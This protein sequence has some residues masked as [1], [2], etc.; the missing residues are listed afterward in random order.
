[1]VLLGAPHRLT[2][3]NIY[4]DYFIPAGSLVF[5]NIW[6]A[7]PFFKKKEATLTERIAAN[8]GRSR[9]IRLRTRSRRGS[10]PSASSIP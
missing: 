10:V 5:A 4:N 9:M 2:E 1:M 7:Q 3:D 6:Y 8:Q